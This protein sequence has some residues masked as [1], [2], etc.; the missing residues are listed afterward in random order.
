MGDTAVKQ[1]LAGKI[2]LK[3][4]S[5]FF[6]YLALS[7]VISNI[8]A[9]WQ[10]QEGGKKREV[11][12]FSK[13]G[14]LLR[15]R[16]PKYLTNGRMLLSLGGPSLCLRSLATELQV[17]NT[18]QRYKQTFIFMNSVP[19]FLLDENLHQKLERSSLKRTPQQLFIFLRKM[20]NCISITHYVV[21]CCHLNSSVNQ[22]CAALSEE[23]WGKRKKKVLKLQFSSGGYFPP[24]I[25]YNSENVVFIKGSPCIFRFL[26]KSD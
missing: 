4:G 24:A 22:I 20:K 23:F 15:R 11:S 8:L 18:A 10:G 16:V 17:H 26:L 5:R 1:S 13:S 19:F 9:W 25:L 3:G 7:S 14:I 12:N 21:Q 6:I 2:W